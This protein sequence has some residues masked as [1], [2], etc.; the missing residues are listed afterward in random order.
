MTTPAQHL[1]ARL[2][3]S[4][5]TGSIVVVVLLAVI[6]LA[7]YLPVIRWQVRLTGQE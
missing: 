1:A 2:G 6:A 4:P 3:V 7:M 5:T